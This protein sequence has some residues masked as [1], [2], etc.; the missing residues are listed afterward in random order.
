MTLAN[1][2]LR[3]NLQSSKG[4]YH[5]QN[6]RLPSAFPSSNQRRST[7]S[8]MICP[9]LLRDMNQLKRVES[10]NKTCD[11]I[12]LAAGKVE[13]ATVMSAERVLPLY[14]IVIESL[15]QTHPRLRLP[16]AGHLMTG[17]SGNCGKMDQTTR[18]CLGFQTLDK[19]LD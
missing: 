13:D 12:Y 15:C 10:S 14:P 16:H 8:M 2:P 17:I 5:V 3:N 7:T 6:R 19:S 9:E 1:V 18:I 11:T 4:R